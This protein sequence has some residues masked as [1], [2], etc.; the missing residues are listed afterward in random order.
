M[1][2]SKLLVI[3]KISKFSLISAL[4]IIISWLSSQFFVVSSNAQVVNQTS[5]SASQSFVS[6]ELQNSIITAIVSGIIG[7]LASFVIERLK[8]QSEPRKQISYSKIIKSGIIGNIEKD[9]EGKIG[10]LYDGKLAQNMIYALFNIENTGNQQ[11]KNQEIRFEFADGSEIL[12]VFNDPQKIEPEMELKEIPESN[13]GKN[14][15]KFRIGVL[16]PTEKLGFRFIVQGNKNLSLDF[17]HHSKNDDDVIFI[18]V[19]DKKVADDIETVNS[20]LINCLIAFVMLPLVKEVLQ[21]SFF[22]VLL[23]LGSLAILGISILPRLEIFIKSAVNLMSESSK[24]KPEVQSERV[25]ILAMEGS[26]VKVGSFT[27]PS[28]TE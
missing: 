21:F 17:K 14:E 2:H 23:S 1:P 22:S 10:I 13:L 18:K 27:L 7:F 11:I 26:S 19:E 28:E 25:G 4:A 9:I 3:S 6:S 15:R 16:K 8:K 5:S 20:F 12:D 24:K